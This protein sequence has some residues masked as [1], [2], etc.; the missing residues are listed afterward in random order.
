MFS[1]IQPSHYSPHEYLLLEQTKLVLLQ[2]G[3]PNMSW[4]PSGVQ[5]SGRVDLDTASRSV[6]GPS[7]ACPLL[8]P[9]C[10]ASPVGL[11]FQEKV[12]WVL[13]MQRVL[14]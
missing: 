4:P 7:P 12:T 14:V 11:N 2:A 1:T 13:P 9:L 3:W 8:V 5:S 6:L 10:P